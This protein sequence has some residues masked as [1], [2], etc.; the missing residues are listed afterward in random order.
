MTLRTDFKMDLRLRRSRPKSFAT[1]A[2][3]DSIDIIRVNVGFH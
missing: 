3:D 1:G 2:F